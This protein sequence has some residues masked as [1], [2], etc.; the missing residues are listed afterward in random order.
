[1]AMSTIDLCAEKVT[2]KCLGWKAAETQWNNDKD[3]DPASEGGKASY[4]TAH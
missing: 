2:V 4:T 1:M 3:K